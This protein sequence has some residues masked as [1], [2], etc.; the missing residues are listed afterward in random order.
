MK[1]AEYVKRKV[2]FSEL[3]SNIIEL[4]SSQAHTYLKFR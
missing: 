4:H 2:I 1:L 3:S